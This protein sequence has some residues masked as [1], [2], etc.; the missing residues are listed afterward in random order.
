MQASRRVVASVVIFTGLLWA[1]TSVGASSPSMTRRVLKAGQFANMKPSNPPTVIRRVSAFFPGAHALESRMRRLG[2][3]A[4]VVEQLQTPGNPNRYGLSEVVQLSSAA[5]AKAALKY[6]YT[7]NGPWDRFA[8]AGIPGAVGFEQVG[9]QGGSNIGFALGPY[10]YLTG[11]GWQGGA[12]NA[13]RNSVL[14]A[15]ALL[16]YDRVR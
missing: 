11:D 10:F 9:A 12:K 3:V 7:T 14:R 16:I 2:F 1:G 13:I 8:V 15:A 5:N 6:Y 4:A